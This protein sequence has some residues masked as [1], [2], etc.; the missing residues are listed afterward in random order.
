MTNADF[1]FCERLLYQQKTHETAIRELE[2][3]LSE[4]LEDLLPSSTAS[5]VD[6]SESK[7]EMIS[8]PERWTIKRDENLRVKDLRYEIQKRKRHK[9]AISEAMRYLDETESQFVFLRYNE[10]KP[11]NYCAM[12]LN[13]WDRK[14]HVPLRTYWRLR[15]KMLEKVAKFLGIR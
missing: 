10:E 13:L 6:M 9:A 12:K 15:T 2:A 3:E 11:H 7:G 8:Q 4:L 1:R 5:F 14:E